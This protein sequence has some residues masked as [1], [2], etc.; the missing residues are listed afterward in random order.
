MT[1]TCKIYEE[2]LSSSEVSKNQISKRYD[3]AKQYLIYAASKRDKIRHLYF[4]INK[5]DLDLIPSCNGIEIDV[6]KLPEY[7]ADSYFCNLA[8]AQGSES[9]IFE[10]IVE[11]IRI[12]SS[13]K[14]DVTI[15]AVVSATLRKWKEFFAKN[16]E[17]ILS[18]ERQQGLY[19]E[20]RFL[21]YL[22]GLRGEKAV[23]CWT[24][25]N[26]ETHD[27]YVDRNA[28]EIKTT[29]TK[30]PYKMHISSEYQLDDK[31]VEGVLF[32]K[33]YALRKSEA[34]GE[35]LVEI[36]TRIRENLKN[37]PHALFMFNEKLEE[38]GY[39][40]VVADKYAAGYSDRME[41]TYRV[42]DNFPRIIS[43][44][45]I[46]GV[47]NCSYEVCVDQCIGYT[48][49]AEQLTLVLKREGNNVR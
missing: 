20:L 27:F 30:A 4:I 10:T 7:D 48:V 18:P 6:V 45:L 29:S 14:P 8:Q 40:D 43:N 26:Y 28:I 49:E 1:L 22:I 17:L 46:N 32:V 37:N 11:D 34:D 38:Y 31:E 5:D 41:S 44:D 16:R 2:L 19:G 21:E 13:E 3:I 47:S 12:K 23:N 39:F 24:G 36:I 33:F 15:P 25:C 9:Y 35:K 42:S